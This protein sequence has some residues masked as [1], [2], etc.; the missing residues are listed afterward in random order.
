MVVRTWAQIV[1]GEEGSV[2]KKKVNFKG[3][4]GGVETKEYSTWKEA[5]EKHGGSEVVVRQQGIPAVYNHVPYEPGEV[6]GVGSS[7]AGVT[8]HDGHESLSNIF[9]DCVSAYLEGV[10]VKASGR[11]ARMDGKKVRIKVKDPNFWIDGAGSPFT[12]RKGLK[13]WF[14]KALDTIESGEKFGLT[15][16]SA[17]I[18]AINLKDI[19]KLYQLFQKQIGG[20][21]LNP[22]AKEW[23]PTLSFTQEKVRNTKWTAP[24]I[25]AEAVP[26]L[27][28]TL[29]N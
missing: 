14:V 17:H 1:K 18:G 16:L 23:I 13:E 20:K 29:V 28:A 11:I 8:K 25:Y 3:G 12:N 6:K 24:I 19:Q 7:F 2:T 27:Q 21:V 22:E 9:S 4:G 10:P 5:T 15:K 26:V